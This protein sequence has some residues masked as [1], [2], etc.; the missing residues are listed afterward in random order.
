ML[1]RVE[2]QILAQRGCQGEL[3]ARHEHGDVGPMSKRA[4]LL[5][6]RMGFCVQT[7]DMTF[8]CCLVRLG[9][10]ERPTPHP[11]GRLDSTA[12]P[13]RPAFFAPPLLRV[14]HS[15]PTHRGCRF[16]AT[17]IVGI[18]VDGRRLQGGMS[19]V[20]LDE[21]PVVIYPARVI[22]NHTLTSSSRGGGRSSRSTWPDQ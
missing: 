11:C 22:L 17:V 16:V 18:Q 3:R 1:H 6:V 19:Q 15:G 21:P 9:V 20:P 14:G 10:R 13:I 12:S 5:S 2:A 7:R 8:G 4:M